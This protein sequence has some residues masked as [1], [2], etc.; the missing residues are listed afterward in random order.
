MMTRIAVL[1]VLNVA[2]AVLS[3]GEPKAASAEITAPGNHEALLKVGSLQRDYWIHVPVKYSKADAT[4]LL[5]VLPYGG[6]RLPFQ[7]DYTHFMP[8]SD[9]HG[10]IMVTAESSKECGIWACYMNCDPKLEPKGSMVG[11]AKAWA[12]ES[13]YFRAVIDD[14][15]KN[16][17]IDKNRIFIVGSSGGGL[18]AYRLS[19]LIADRIT[20]AGIA[21]GNFVWRNEYYQTPIPTPARPVSI[22][23]FHG[24]ADKNVSY[25]HSANA[26]ITVWS[27]H[28]SAGFWSKNNGCNS[29]PE[30]ETVASSR[31]HNAKVES[32]TWP[33]PKGGATVALYTKIG[34]GHEYPSY[35]SAIMWDFFTKEADRRFPK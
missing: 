27:A 32:E 33:A 28:E 13:A 31:V 24:D 18:M 5:I 25:G 7:D 22:I 20:G 21:C 30:K 12:D 2:M 14:V 19:V 9:E 11:K 8:L 34:G 29:E 15:E 35:A 23:A 1:A 6:G 10:F 3:A 4:P 26:N 16:F 17:N